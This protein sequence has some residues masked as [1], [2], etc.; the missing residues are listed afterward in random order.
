MLGWFFV[1]SGR[2]EDMFGGGMGGR[3][4]EGAFNVP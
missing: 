4:V 3:W 1:G 2:C